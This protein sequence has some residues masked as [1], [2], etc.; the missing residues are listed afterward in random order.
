MLVLSFAVEGVG[1][2]AEID[3]MPYIYA[4]TALGA[5]VSPARCAHRGGPLHLATIAPGDTRMVCP[6]HEQATA[7]TRLIS[8]GIPA[9]RSGGRVTAVFPSPADASTRTGH[10]PLSP[11]LCRAKAAG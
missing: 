11:D 3:G 8:K 1:N 4:R 9:V 6:W 5:F 2:C 10:L 7:T